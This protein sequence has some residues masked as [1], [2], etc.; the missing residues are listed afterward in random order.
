MS[1]AVNA[2]IDDWTGDAV[3]LNDDVLINIDP[4][5]EKFEGDSGL[6]NYV[7]T[8]SLTA[9]YA[10]PVSVG[11]ATVDGTA[12]AA[13]NDYLPASGTVTFPPGQTARPVIVQAVGD[14]RFESSETFRVVLSNPVN[15]VI[16]DDNAIAAVT[17]DDP[18]TDAGFSVADGSKPEGNTGTSPLVFTVSLSQLSN[19]TLSVDFQTAD[20]TAIAP[21]DYASVQGTLLF[22]PGEAS[23]TVAV[24]IS[25]DTVFES[26]ETFTLVLSN[27]I[28][29][30]IGDGSATG[31][32]LNDDAGSVQVSIDDV[33][34]IEGDSGPSGL[35]FT[36]TLLSPTEATI[37]IGYT[38]VGLTATEHVDF[39]AGAGTVLFAPL[40]TSAPLVVTIAGDTDFEIDETLR[41]DL[42]SSMPGVT[43]VRSSGIGTILDEDAVCGSRPPDVTDL[44]LEM[45][46]A[47][48]DLRFT[49][50]D[51][52]GA[53]EYWL[54]ECGWRPSEPCTGPVAVAATG[55]AGIVIP[56]TTGSGFYLMASATVA[57]GPGPR[58]LCA[59]DLC[60][61]GAR[62]DS[63]CNSCAAAVC[64]QDPACCSDGWSQSCVDSVNAACG[65]VICPGAW[66][67]CAHS[68]CIFGPALAPG[69]DDPPVTPS[70]VSAICAVNPF[71][72]S[73][74]W[75]AVC[76]DL[77]EPV[78]GLLCE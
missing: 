58:H 22:Q 43:L 30:S 52:A 36:L 12:T 61:P 55:S 8:V 23:K 63:S 56:S 31:T 51:V 41:V 29:A 9:P 78:C 67:S 54:Y 13:D 27:P 59:H 4:D 44:K 71:C 50:T 14:V 26:D 6:T 53:D 45:I 60:T 66:G 68:P 32:I 10:L 62:L 76:S 73:V 24:P 39:V 7:F 5:R 2:V 17:N 1:N 37:S 28:G 33:A 38:T 34:A 48:A 70:C 40:Q 49:W 21:A 64:D 46:N 25:G 20:G 69:C 77:V 75:Y 19:D 16:D 15:A 18:L 57:C 11:W 74:F 3:L 42:S 35:A 47:G 65:S 72:C